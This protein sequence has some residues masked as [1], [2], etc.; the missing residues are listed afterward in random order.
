M[1]SMQQSLKMMGASLMLAAT[2]SSFALGGTSGT[3]IAKSG[4][5]TNTTKPA[6]SADVS[7]KAKKSLSHNFPDAEGIN[8]VETSNGQMYTA[9]FKLFDVKTV[10]SF[11]KEGQLVNILRYYKEDHLP[12]DVLTLLKSRYADKKVAGVTEFSKA[13][14]DDIAYYI[15]LEDKAHWY[16]VRI[17][18]DD[19]T[20]TERLDKQL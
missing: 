12:L 16:T 14:T 6:T 20:Q 11:D 15:K 10:A 17:I 13:D 9:Y 2:L 4:P 18:G 5:T 1:K 3:S 7:E 8:W 19:M